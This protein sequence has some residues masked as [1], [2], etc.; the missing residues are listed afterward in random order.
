MLHEELEIHRNPRNM[1]LNL[2]DL[3]SRQDFWD[4]VARSFNCMMMG[5]T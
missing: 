1:S 5:L 4:R 3:K 2:E